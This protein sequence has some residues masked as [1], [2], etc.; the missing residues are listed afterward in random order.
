MTNFTPNLFNCMTK[1]GASGHAF[2]VRYPVGYP[3]NNPASMRVSGHLGYPGYPIYTK[4][5]CG[6][7]S[8]DAQRKPAPPMRA[9]LLGKRIPWIPCALFATAP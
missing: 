8:G 2:R 9:P 7:N 1:R 6:S 4:E 3:A 5:W